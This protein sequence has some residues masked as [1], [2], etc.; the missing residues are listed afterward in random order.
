MQSS[1][2]GTVKKLKSLDQSSNEINLFN[3][4]LNNRKF[5]EKVF[6]FLGLLA[7][8]HQQI[9]KLNLHAYS[10]TYFLFLY[11]TK[12]N[13]S[14]GRA[15]WPPHPSSLIVNYRRKTSL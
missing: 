1:P 11:E 14:K 15:I 7:T 10:I 2:N 6:E 5:S 8:M 3:L 12:A 9:Y 13:I 4:F